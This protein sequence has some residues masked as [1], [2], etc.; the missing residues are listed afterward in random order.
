MKINWRSEIVSLFLVAAMFILAAAAWNSMPGSIPVHFGLNGQPDRYGGKF[1][2]LLSMPLTATGL[3]LLFFFL[4]RIDPHGERYARFAGAYTVI[5][6]AVIALLAAVQVAIILQARGVAID[7]STI[8]TLAMGLL[9]VVLGN[10]MGKIRP[11]WFVGIRTPW[12]LS[13]EESWNKT[14]RLGGKMLVTLGLLIAASS[15]LQ[16]PWI[17]LAGVG[18][19]LVI[20]VILSV[21]SYLIW[22]NDPSA[23]KNTR[24]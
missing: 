1:E 5:R 19:L 14:H 4:P 2:G 20:T 11:N 12:T 15:L 22:K 18:L 13:S 7:V 8:V 21:Y 17:L 3:Y 9:F 10:Y 16:K 23:R 6:T 24:G